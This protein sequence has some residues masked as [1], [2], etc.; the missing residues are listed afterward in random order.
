MKSTGK[1]INFSELP[2]M[3]LL[4]I[5]RAVPAKR[6][7]KMTEKLISKRRPAL[8]LDR[9]LT[10]TSNI[11]LVILTIVVF[12]EVIM[13]YV[14]SSPSNV[15]SGLTAMIFPWMIFF[16]AIA[17]TQNN[18]HIRVNYFRNKLPAFLQK[19]V[20]VITKLIMLFF[21]I[22]MVIS[23]YGLVESVMNQAHPI[24]GISRGWLYGSVTVSFLGMGIVLL[25]Q[26]FDEITSEEEK[27]GETNDL[28]YDH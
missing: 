8:M 25:F 28:D 22:Y 9:I 27:R 15:T 14:F 21:S 23:S 24:L 6:G 18:D 11:L 1:K 2:C 4:F 16:A 13:R 19:V 7:I 5:G 20:N 26:I 10:T 17:V 3:N 12:G